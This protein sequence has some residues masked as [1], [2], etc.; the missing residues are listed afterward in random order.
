VEAAGR[1]L[2]HKAASLPNTLYSEKK[3]QVNISPEVTVAGRIDLIRRLDTGLT[4]IV[5][6][7]SS[8]RAQAEDITRD[9][10]HVYALGHEKLT[11]S[12][13]DLI[14]VLNCRAGTLSRCRHSPRA[15]PSRIRAMGT[16]G[17]VSALL[18]RAGR[19]R[20]PVTPVA[21]DPVRG[22]SGWTVG[23]DLGSLAI[24]VAGIC[25]RKNVHRRRIILSPVP[26]D[27]NPDAAPFLLHSWNGQEKTGR[28]VEESDPCYETASKSQDR[29]N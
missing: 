14:E 13:A 24:P 5:D 27:C 2:R 19:L 29:D 10:L 21:L 1:Y 6:F 28:S 25:S 9:Q 16:D 22:R 23:Q 12:S 17:R 20:S 4:S 18:T 7:K 26:N 8:E 15:T 3:I 11:G